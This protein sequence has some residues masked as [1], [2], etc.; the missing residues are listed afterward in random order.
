[1]LF[2][3]IDKLFNFVL[4]YDSIRLPVNFIPYYSIKEKHFPAMKELWLEQFV[5]VIII[6]ALGHF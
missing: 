2:Q 1:M 5:L 3:V 4:V 6:D